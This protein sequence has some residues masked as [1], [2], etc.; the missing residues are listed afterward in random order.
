MSRKGKRRKKLKERKR[1]NR[2]ILVCEIMG[3]KKEFPRSGPQT[4]RAHL[5][6][7]MQKPP[8]QARTL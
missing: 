5:C 8:F 3:E 4:S 6:P 1:E 2:Y 7:Q